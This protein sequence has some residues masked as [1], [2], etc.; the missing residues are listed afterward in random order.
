MGMT[1]RERNYH[2]R[3]AFIKKLR[4]KILKNLSGSYVRDCRVSS[5]GFDFEEDGEPLFLGRRK[6]NTRIY[7]L[8]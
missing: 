2:F 6:K 8:K 4:S 5:V 3:R 1:K 7:R